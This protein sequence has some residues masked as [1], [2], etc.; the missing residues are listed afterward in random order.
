M[1]LS[2]RGFAGE[3]CCAAPRTRVFCAA[4][5]NDGQP[6]P[7]RP[8]ERSGFR[9]IRVLGTQ[10]LITDYRSLARHCLHWARQEG[11]RAMDFAN[12]QTVTMHRH[13]NGFRVLSGSL[14]YMAPDGM[15]FARPGLADRPKPR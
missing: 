6:Q 5:L 3:M 4:H 8:A 7:I 9:T 13:E 2:G 15:P 1:V 10:L 11:C 12:T 14:D